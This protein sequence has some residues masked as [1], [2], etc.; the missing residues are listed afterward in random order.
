MSKECGASSATFSAKSA[1]E[2]AEEIV[3]SPTKLS[4]LSFTM[5]T[6][7]ALFEVIGEVRY[8]GPHRHPSSGDTVDQC[9]VS[10]SVWKV[11]LWK[12]WSVAS[13]ANTF[14]HFRS[15]LWFCT[16]KTHKR[17]NATAGLWL[18]N[19]GSAQLCFWFQLPR[20]T[21]SDENKKRKNSSS[22]AEIQDLP[23][24]CIS[25]G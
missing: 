5:F 13:L 19:E 24:P 20:T 16:S 3:L 10:W 21:R 11:L 12:K 1:V 15:Y 9:V 7:S 18:A 6:P 22:P 8:Y 23:P 2:P 14:S 4:V 17:K 25:R